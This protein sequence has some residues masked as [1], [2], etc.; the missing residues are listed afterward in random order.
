MNRPNPYINTFYLAVHLALNILVVVLVINI[1][2]AFIP[3]K[4]F[5]AG[6]HLNI[7]LHSFYPPSTLEKNIAAIIALGVA[8]WYYQKRKHRNHDTAEKYH[9]PNLRHLAEEFFKNKF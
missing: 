5:F 2:N 6:Y 8:V 1:I 3:I 9:F 4:H 7:N